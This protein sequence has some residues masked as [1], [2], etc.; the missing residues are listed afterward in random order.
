MMMMIDSFQPEGTTRIGVD[1]IFMM[2]HLGVLSGIDREAAMQVFHRD[3]LVMLGTCVAAS[4][5]TREGKKCLEYRITRDGE[6]TEGELAFGELAHFPLATGKSCTVEIEPR[7]G[8]DMGEGRGTTLQTEC[9][10][11][12]VGIIIDARGRPLEL[13]EDPEESARQVRRWAQS[14][15]MYPEKELVEA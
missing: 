8:L 1:S 12:E 2:P 11:G 13:P 9:E 6:E 10:G 14:V 15:S 5:Q 4:G 7:R 3:C